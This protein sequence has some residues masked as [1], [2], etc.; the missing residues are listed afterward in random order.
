MISL[1]PKCNILEFNTNYAK[2][3]DSK[4]VVHHFVFPEPDENDA[5]CK[6]HCRQTLGP[7]NQGAKKVTVLVQ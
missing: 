7:K 1:A 3:K 2:I 6:Q 4:S 5:V